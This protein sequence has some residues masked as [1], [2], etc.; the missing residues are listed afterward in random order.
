LPNPAK[1]GAFAKREKEDYVSDLHIE[2]H[3]QSPWF[4]AHEDKYGLTNTP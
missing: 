1:G 2:P 3:G 4:F